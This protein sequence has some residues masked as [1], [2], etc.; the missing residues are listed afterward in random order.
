MPP[1]A[2]LLA[3]TGVLALALG[4]SKREVGGAPARSADAPV[5]LARTTDA[6]LLASA[7][8]YVAYG[9]APGHDRDPS[10]PAG[11]P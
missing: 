1:S 3:L 6:L 9:F 2:W 10:R 11:F 8:G 4:V 7:L 5:A